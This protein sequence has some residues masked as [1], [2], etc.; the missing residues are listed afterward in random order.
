ME[1]LQISRTTL[2]RYR[3][4]GLL[5]AT[6]LPTGQY[7]FDADTAIA[8]IKTLQAGYPLKSAKNSLI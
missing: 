7:D 4:K 6:R 1:L 5:K 8:A 2:K 3:E